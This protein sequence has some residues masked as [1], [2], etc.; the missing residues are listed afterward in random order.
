MIQVLNAAYT[1]AA[2]SLLLLAAR[3]AV[4]ALS[5]GR[6]ASN[7]VHRALVFLT[8]PLIRIARWLSP[9]FV[10]DRHLPLV[11]FLLCL[12]ACLGFAVGL[13]RLVGAAG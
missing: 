10:L 3:F 7:P 1:L 4:L 6:H 11:A 8:S 2:F 13:P 5:F 12:W 9:S